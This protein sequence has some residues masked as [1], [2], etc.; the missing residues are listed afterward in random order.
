M[1]RQHGQRCGQHW[2]WH[3]AVVVAGGG[4]DGGE[5][6]R[7][8]S[9]CDDDDD[10]DHDDGDWLWGLQGAEQRRRRVEVEL[11]ERTRVSSSVAEEEMKWCGL[12]SS[13]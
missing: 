1:G 3:A 10:D 2:E 8:A 7:L 5:S 4:G 6:E 13:Q 11:V 12:A 9:S